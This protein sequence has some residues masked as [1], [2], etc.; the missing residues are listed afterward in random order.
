ML[1]LVLSQSANDIHA[2]ED[3]HVGSATEG[4]RQEDEEEKV[5][6]SSSASIFAL[7]SITERE[8]YSTG[9]IRVGESSNVGGMRAT[10]KYYTPVVF[11]FRCG[12][13]FDNHRPRRRDRYSALT[14]SLKWCRN[15]RHRNGGVL[16]NGARAEAAQ[17]DAQSKAVTPSNSPP[18]A[19]RFRAFH[20]SKMDS[21]AFLINA[22]ELE[23]LSLPKAWRRRWILPLCFHEFDKRNLYKCINLSVKGTRDRKHTGSSMT[24]L[25]RDQAGCSTG[26]STCP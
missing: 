24:L 7:E 3:R 12:N 2:I 1:E 11:N 9:E 14:N 19:T 17:R 22:S 18:I 16:G 6:Q 15:R 13:N 20:R 10:G 21:I 23:Q 25:R 26:T 4:P 5:K 8:Y